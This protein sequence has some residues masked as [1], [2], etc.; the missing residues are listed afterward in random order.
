MLQPAQRYL[1]GLAALAALVVAITVYA[2]SATDGRSG[3]HSGGGV[4]ANSNYTLRGVL[5]QLVAGPASNAAGN[6]CSGIE[7]GVSVPVQPTATSTPSP[8][9]TL[10]TPTS[11][12]PATTTGTVTPETPTA[13]RVPVTATVEVRD[14]FFAPDP[15]TI[16]V[17]DTV[18]WVRVE[19]FHN[20]RADD[21]SFRLGENPAGD[22]GSTWSTVS[23][24]FTQPGTFR[25]HCEAHGGPGGNG[26]AGTVIVLAPDP[27]PVMTPSPEITPPPGSTTTPEPGGESNRTYL[28]IIERP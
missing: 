26:M 1:V 20:V 28:P 21:G 2:T 7:C 6:L 10:E 8:T 15:I 23:H 16:S 25:Y 13:T 5:G 11:T 12:T 18:T 14:N 3:I 4:V 27:T 9:G 17:G 19:G 24:I 22:P